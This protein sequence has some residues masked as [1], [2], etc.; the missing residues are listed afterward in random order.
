M[1]RPSR[2]LVLLSALAISTTAFAQSD[3]GLDHANNNASFLRCGTRSPSD[4]E[5]KMVDEHLR[6]LQKGKPG[7]GGGGLDPRRDWLRA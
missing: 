6:S 7:G 2:T 3:T 1:I 5:A 4:I